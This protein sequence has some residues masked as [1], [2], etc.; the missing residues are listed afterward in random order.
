MGALVEEFQ[1]PARFYAKLLGAWV[2][3]GFRSPK[4]GVGAGELSFEQRS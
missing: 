3:M 2:A 1:R 4:I